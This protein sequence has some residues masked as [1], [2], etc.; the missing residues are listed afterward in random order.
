LGVG[1][2]GGGGFRDDPHSDI[3]K[4]ESSMIESAGV[5]PSGE[6]FTV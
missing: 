2:G 4:I 6:T 3:L 5:F 1:M